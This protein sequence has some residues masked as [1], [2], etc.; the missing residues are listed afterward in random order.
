MLLILLAVHLLSRDSIAAPLRHYPDARATTD[1]CKDI[2]NCR[3]LSSVVWGCLATIFA[4]TWVSVHLN[5]P[6]PKQ[7]RLQLFWRRLKMMLIAMIAPEI[8]VGFAARQRL[9][10]HIL[11]KKFGFSTT[12][13]MFFSMGGFVTSDQHPIATIE[14]LEDSP[15]GSEFQAAIQKISLWF[16]LQTLARAHQRL[17]VTQLEVATL[18]FA[19][20][21]IFIWLL[22]WNKSLDIQRP[23]VVGPD[24]ETVTLP[25]RLSLWTRFGGAISGN[26]GGGYEPLSFVSVPSFWSLENDGGLNGA[27]LL[28][29]LVGTLFGTIHCAAWNAVFPTH[30]EMWIWRMSALVITVY[31]GFP[32]LIVPM[33]TILGD[34]L[35]TTLAL[36]SLDIETDGGRTKVQ[37]RGDAP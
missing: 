22:W 10:A 1:S 24:T 9:G 26:Y 28:L 4:C 36:G 35:S 30:R 16:I 12:H 7:S 23:I 13:G 6:P 32:L 11:W 8:M 5:V 21:N 37:D 25:G 3:T 27:D 14:Q 2:D 15:L 17:A 29:S 31:P 18:A 34:R 19:V 20:V 33:A